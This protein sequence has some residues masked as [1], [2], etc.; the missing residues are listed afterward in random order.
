MTAPANLSGNTQNGDLL[1]AGQYVKV[2]QWGTAPV[3]SDGGAL[4]LEITDMIGYGFSSG[5]SAV[6][7]DYC[8]DSP[9]TRAQAAILLVRGVYG[10]DN[11]SYSI[12][13][14]FNDVNASS[15]GFQWIQKLFE[16][17]ITSGCGNGNY[18][19]DM[20][21]PRDQA[22][23][24][25]VRSRFGSGTP[26]NN[27]QT[28]YFTD[29]PANAFAFSYIQRLRMDNITAGC[30]PTAFCPSQP[31]TRGELAVFIMRALTNQFLPTGMPLISEVTSANQP[32][33]SL[34]FYQTTT[35]IIRGQNTHFDQTSS[36]VVAGGIATSNFTVYS[37]TY[38]TVD[39]QGDGQTLRDEPD[40]IIITTGSEQAVMP[41]AI[42][43]EGCDLC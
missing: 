27:P 3:V 32:V 20:N 40:S 37:P 43:F 28:P 11:F 24:L 5:C 31:V 12:T 10:N 42:M 29:V 9:V 21:L 6:P 41:N 22:A 15:F 34:F 14:H 17:G 39:V 26:F 16:L 2:M 33:R 8:P 23:I 13:P 35:L 19:P 7:L 25:I 36:I 30:T 18:C 1:I 4:T 38:A